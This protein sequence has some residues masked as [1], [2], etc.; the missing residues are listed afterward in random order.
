MSVDDRIRGIHNFLS[1]I[2]VLQYAS[3]SRTFSATE[4]LYILVTYMYMSTRSRSGSERI[5]YVFYSNHVV[6][7]F[8]LVSPTYSM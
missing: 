5:W 3:C 2:F 4:L 6:V 7:S 1:E 8:L